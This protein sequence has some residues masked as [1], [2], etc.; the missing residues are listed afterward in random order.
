MTDQ[1][2]KSI[3]FTLWYKDPAKF[4]KDIYGM[5]PYPYQAKVLRYLMD[6]KKRRIILVA[7]GGTGKTKLLACIALWLTLV[8]PKFI[9]RSY[10]VIII[11]GSQDQ[12]RYLYEYSKYAVS[13][14]KIL[15]EEVE[16]EPLM[17]VTHFK[18]RSI[19]M[20]VPNSLKAIQGKHMDCVIVDE[21]ALAGDF[22]I[23]DTLRIV[24]TSDR[25]LIILSGTPMVY[26]STFVEY[27]DNVDRYPEWERFTWAAS[28][29]PEISKEKWEEAKKLPE[30]MFVVFWEGKPYAKTGTL[31][32]TPEIKAV[33]KD[34]PNVAPDPRY[35][36]V[37]GLDWGWCLSG[38]TEVL[39]KHGWK[40]LNNCSINEDIICLDQK[41]FC[42]KYLPIISITSKPYHGI[43]THISSRNI[44]VLCK[45]R[46]IIPYLN[47][48]KQKLHLHYAY[49][50]TTHHYIIRKAKFDGINDPEIIIGNK[51]YDTVNFMKLLG[52]YLSEG[53]CEKTRFCIHQSF[54]VNN[55][56]CKEI[57]DL[58]KSLGIHTWTDNYKRILF[59][60]KNLVNYFKSLGHSY[61]KYIPEYLKEY[62]GKILE[63]L[64][65]TLLKGDGDK[66]FPR[67]NTYSYKLAEDVQEIAIKTGKYH[68]YIST[69]LNK[70]YRVNFLSRDSLI[71]KCHYKDVVINGTCVSFEV[72]TGIILTR[73]NGKVSYQHNR[74]YTGLVICQKIPEIN[75]IYVVYTD[76]WRREDFED[77]HQKIEQIC[78]DYNVAKLYTDAEDIGENQRLEA[79][80]LNVV[81][82]AFNQ[83][84]IQ[85]QSHMKVVFH[86]DK[87]RV[88]ESYKMLIQQLRKYNWNT[89]EDDDL[90]DALQLA[91]WSLKDDENSWYY[92][93]L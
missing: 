22:I 91:L 5:E 26:S 92:E 49:E 47:R 45:P 43:M 62:D 18:D 46:H 65:E 20:A 72:P 61:T 35:E 40:Q 87:I 85:M 34:Q 83:N 88:P 86:Q 21:G 63:S 54:K 38:D 30:D 80:G 84:K 31:I 60:D 93:V 69:R 50:H 33:S 75:M 2:L 37:A 36:V 64:L 57:L 25:D 17:S 89:K 81:P 1:V 13:D 11:S 71:N 79:R 76:A 78:K 28:D 19:I 39:T 7:A 48:N 59:Y 55:N 77:M 42:S 53:S 29:C 51:S 3:K 70:G 90:V 16:G 12:A 41:T 74:H 6:P 73:R 10:S 58:G 82:I 27:Y 67:Y 44:D 9:G 15:S 52:W 32:P 8:L 56:Y 23:Q 66:C 68:S 14:N 24:S 4:F